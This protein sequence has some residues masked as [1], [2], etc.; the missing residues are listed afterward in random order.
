MPLVGTIYERVF[1]PETYYALDTALMFQEAVHN[2]VL[3]VIDGMISAKGLRAL[4]E[5]ERKPILKV[6]AQSA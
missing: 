3:E 4:S 1:A 6:F 2:A 5:V